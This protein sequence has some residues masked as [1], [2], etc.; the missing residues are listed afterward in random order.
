ML[1]PS[2]DGEVLPEPEPDRILGE[3]MHVGTWQ[4]G[5]GSVRPNRS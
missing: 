5:K 2:S 4:P 3:L 1:A